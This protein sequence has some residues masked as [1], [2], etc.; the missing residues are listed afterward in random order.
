[1]FSSTISCRLSI[2]CSTR[3]DTS[4]LLITGDDCDGHHSRKRCDIS[5]PPVFPTSVLVTHVIVYKLAQRSTWSQP[6]LTSVQFITLRLIP[7]F[8]QC[9]LYR[10]RCG[11]THPLVFQMPTL[12]THV[13]AH[14]YAHRSTWHIYHAWHR[15]IPSLYDLLQFT[16][17][18]FHAHR[19]HTA[20][21]TI[22]CSHTHRSNITTCTITCASHLSWCTLPHVLL[23]RHTHAHTC[24]HVHI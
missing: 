2:T 15:Y 8:F 20:T 22:A 17:A 12:A 7:I 6:C 16:I 11:E 14:E 21:C 4:L 24:V 5:P 9:I 1:M 13:M 10:E 3:D 19:W 23:L 18:C